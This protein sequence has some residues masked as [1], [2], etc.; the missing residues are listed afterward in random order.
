MVGLHFS[1]RVIDDST[2]RELLVPRPD[3]PTLRQFFYW[4]EKDNDI[5]QI[6]RTRRT[7]RVYDKDMR[8]LLGTLTG[9][10]DGPGARYQIDATIGDV[11]LVSRYDRAKIV[12]RPVIYVVIDVF[13]HLIVGLHVGFKGPSWVGAMEALTTAI[14]SKVAF[15]RRFDIDITDAD[16]PSQGLPVAL[17][18]DR[19]EIAD[20]MI[21]TLINNFGLDVEN[22]AP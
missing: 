15:C 10:T 7:P 13:S 20:S 3:T 9:E 19:G 11:Y 6:E 16:W 2:G 5:F 21:E 4:Y 12:G 14:G 18:G 8:A 1:D 17:L 22:A